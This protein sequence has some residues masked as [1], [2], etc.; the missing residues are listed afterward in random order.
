MIVLVIFV[1]LVVVFVPLSNKE[2]GLLLGPREQFICSGL[3]LDRTESH[4]I[5]TYIYTYIEI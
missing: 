2:V 4:T 1:A 3:L 5:Y